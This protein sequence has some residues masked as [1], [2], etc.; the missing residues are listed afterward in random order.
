M[1]L[2]MTQGEVCLPTSIDGLAA[3]KY[4]KQFMSENQ[5]ELDRPARRVLGAAMWLAFPCKQ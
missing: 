4:V 5:S 3:Q 1:T 2:E